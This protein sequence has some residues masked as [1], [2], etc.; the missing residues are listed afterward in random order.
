[1]LLDDKIYCED[2]WSPGGV[3][4]TLL[5]GLLGKLNHNTKVLDVGCGSA[6]ASINLSLRF[7]CTCLAFDSEAEYVE[8]ARNN[9]KRY[10][11]DNLVTIIHC[12]LEEF[13][14]NGDVYDMVIAEGGVGSYVGHTELFQFSRHMLRPGGVLALSD[15]VHREGILSGKYV[16]D[17]DIPESIIKFYEPG[18]YAN[19]KGHRVTESIIDDKLLISGFYKTLSFELS[20]NHWSR[21]R[22]NMNE[23]AKKHTGPA[24]RDPEF[25]RTIH[26]EESLWA[27]EAQK[28]ISYYYIIA[29]LTKISE[30]RVKSE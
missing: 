1:M 26:H 5:A 19:A 28:Y 23:H 15:I 17:L 12:P 16:L 11:V 9:V 21:Y 10:G 3:E 8:L 18:V 29:H 13:E 7:G 6:A 14:S 4:L 27:T 30:Q 20:K 24:K 2:C 22:N 25:A